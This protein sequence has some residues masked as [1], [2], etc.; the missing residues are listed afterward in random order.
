MSLWIR[1]AIALLLLQNAQYQAQ[2]AN[3]GS[4]PAA[5]E[6]IAASSEEPPPRLVFAKKDWDLTKA[7]FDVFAILSNEN[8]CSS[9]YGGSRTATIVL[10]D[11]VMRVKTRPLLR[12]ISFQMM[13]RPRLIRDP[14]TGAFYRL[15]DRATVNSNG[16][17]YQRRVDPMR[18]FPSDVGSF[19]PG[20]R[21]ARALILLHELGHLIQ[22]EDGEWLIPDDGYDGEQSKANTLLVQQACRAQLKALR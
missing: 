3:A 2:E 13:G 10:N 7:Y 17:F 1:S 22:G 16:S 9:F 4:R 20:S 21:P 12:E 11:F 19:A 15:F 5:I 14:A 18:K 6:E 8:T